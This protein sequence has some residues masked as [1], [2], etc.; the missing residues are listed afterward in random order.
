MKHVFFRGSLRMIRSSWTRFL[1]IFAITTLGVAFFAG[2]RATAPDMRATAEAYFDKTRL[3]DFRLVSTAGFTDADVDAVR[4]TKGVSVVTPAY[5][6]DAIVNRS[7]TRLTVKLLSQQAGSGAV[8]RPALR[9]GRM[10]DAPGECLAD[11]RFIRASG[12]RVG[13]EVTVTAGSGGDLSGTLTTSALRVVGVADSSLYIS[14]DRG[15]STIGTGA[16][17]AYLLLDSRTFSLPVYT[18]LDVTVRNPSGISRFSDRYDSLL[19]PVNRALDQVGKTRSQTR[20][21]QW[22][23]DGQKQVADAKAK[24]ADARQRLADAAA[25]LEQAWGQI[26]EGQTRLAQAQREY[27]T[28]VAAARQKLAAAQTQLTQGQADYAQKQADFA[29]AQAE[30]QASSAALERQ[31]AA[32]GLGGLTA[33]QLA[34]Q[35]TQLKQAQSALPAASSQ[36]QQLAGQ[37]AV[38]SALIGPQRQ[39]EAAAAQLAQ[40]QAELTAAGAQLDASRSQLAQQTA[41]F[42]AQR[43][44][45]QTQLAAQRSRLVAAKQALARG[46]TEY[47]NQKAQAQP[48]IEAAE[49]AIADGEQTL[50]ALKVP[51]W[52][53]LDIHTNAG[54]VSFKQDADRIAALSVTFPL[55]FF[56]VA[57]LVSLTAMTR[58]VEEDRTAVGTLKALGYGRG[59]IA[60]RY[61]FFAVAASLLGSAAGLA[62][63]FR[64]FPWVIFR[65]YR[66]LYTMPDIRIAFN[67]TY[68]AISTAAAVFCAAVP[69]WLVCLRSLRERPAALMRPR[70]PR[71]GR[72]IL[73]ERMTPLW[74]RLN[75]SR[76]VACRNLF[77]YKKRMAMTVAGV[78]GCTALL[79]TGFGLKDSISDIVGRQYG[80]IRVYD[81]MAELKDGASA[82]DIGG[83]ADAVSAEG[84][85]SLAVQQ[86]SLDALHGSRD[87][88]VYLVVPQDTARLP[89]F[90]RLHERVGRRSLAPTD[91]TVVISEKLASTLS[92]RVGGTFRLRDSSGRE[93]TVKV[94]GIAENY[95]YHY[96]Y[97][98][99]GLYRQL[100][101][102]D[103]APNQLMVRLAQPA[104]AGA[105]A[106]GLMK[107]SSVTAVVQ[108]AALRSTFQKMIRALNT[109]V[110][111][112]ILSAAALAMVVLV[113]LTSITIDER[114]REL[115]TLRVLG[116]Y[117]LETAAYIGRENVALTVIGTV[118]G[119]LGGIFLERYVI[120]TVEVDLVMFGRRILWSSYLF[121]VLL[122][123]GFSMLVNIGMMRRIRRIDMVGSLKSSE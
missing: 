121:S 115:A 113:S 114:E 30:Y 90:I 65:A 12:C 110:L 42:T 94:G 11:P 27:D 79:L 111:V 123:L 47:E 57:A 36:A 48:Q 18:E 78:A 44:Q 26:A 59:R 76:K 77:R 10:P 50:A 5:S 31:K 106:S 38:L 84:G 108:S 54:F 68:A 101:G 13:D 8:N 34:D 119:L 71:A 86:E 100:F 99:P 56:L 95:V 87:K 74:N 69:A 109:V 2:L 17:D 96:V 53:V 25:H 52:Y 33:A 91:S 14:Y 3:M 118:L 55:I 105:L 60:S 104:R 66:I 107:M 88:S 116:F 64:L 4:R 61:L 112:L 67:P 117:P 37:I 6:A 85:K 122:T 19:R 81:L 75:F 51:Q 23:Q 97:M 58:L 46:E 16:V 45:G 72:R 120:T 89:Q 103:S 80:D 40:G 83:V 21:D 43:Q 28:A 70:A 24:L 92:L 22:Q 49:K 35:L 63:G 102:R 32:V 15:T 82:A 93:V 73:L 29:K 41:A 9:S 20:Y 62:G 7:G 98:T 1:A 39:V